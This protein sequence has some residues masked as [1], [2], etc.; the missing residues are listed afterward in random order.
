MP[1][2]HPNKKYLTRLSAVNLQIP[3]HLQLYTGGGLDYIGLEQGNF[4]YMIVCD[5]DSAEIPT[6]PDQNCSIVRLNWND[7]DD[8]P[9]VFTGTLTE[10]IAHLQSL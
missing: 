7:E 10:A 9:V 5:P 4:T 6:E 1:N 3:R 8:Y 2:L